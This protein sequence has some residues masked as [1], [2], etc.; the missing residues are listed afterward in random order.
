MFGRRAGS[1][2]D[3]SGQVGAA[4]FA[5]YPINAD[6]S[7]SIEVTWALRHAAMTTA[8][9]ASIVFQSDPRGENAIGGVGGDLG[10]GGILPSIAVELDMWRDVNDPAYQHIGLDRDG[11]V[12]TTDPVVMTPFDLTTV[13]T[14][15]LWIDYTGS[16]DRIDVFIARS[17]KPATPVLTAIEDLTRLGPSIWFGLTHRRP[18]Q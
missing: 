18:H 13:V 15:T 3:A 17:T 9:G 7:F 10:L 6:T 2:A 5:Q 16:A 14:F 12:D 4:W 11:D 1:T 8:D